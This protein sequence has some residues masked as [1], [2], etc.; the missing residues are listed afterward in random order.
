[1]RRESLTD[2]LEADSAT[3][4]FGTELGVFRRE[5]LLGVVSLPSRAVE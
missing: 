4:Q 5:L 2:F 1:M 3:V